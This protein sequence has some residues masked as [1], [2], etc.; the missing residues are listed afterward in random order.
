MANH[1][2][3]V[4]RSNND[5]RKQPS[6]KQPVISQYQKPERPKTLD[7]QSTDVN[8]STHSKSL[9]FDE[10]EEWKK[11]TEIMA[12]FGT[13]SDILQE[14]NNSNMHCSHDRSENGRSTAQIDRQR[15]AMKKMDS[16]KR[17]IQRKSGTQSQHNILF[18]FLCEHKIDELSDTLVD[19]GYDD[20]EF[21]RGI[22][23]ESDLDLME[24]KPE[25]RVK[26]MKSIDSNLQT[27]ARAIT[28]FTKSETN[29]DKTIFNKTLSRNN[30]ESHQNAHNEIASNCE[31]NSN[32]NNNNYS[33]ISK[34]TNHNSPETNGSLSVNDWL[35]GIK[36]PQYAD[37]FR[38]VII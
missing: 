5:V 36:L 25:L 17:N 30:D 16:M 18:N 15:N 24:I 26:L 29:S 31:I 11:I 21:V 33:T 32:G 22:L 9:P 6:P 2:L 10:R 38:Q 12:N 4:C 1:L 3:F 34:Q 37:V 20:I 23:D 13:D 7:T 14:F 35:N 27:P 28:T 19:N 8:T